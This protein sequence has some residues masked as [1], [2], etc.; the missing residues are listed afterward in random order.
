VRKVRTMARKM[1]S[2]GIVEEIRELRKVMEEMVMVLRKLAREMK[3]REEVGQESAGVEVRTE[4]E[5]VEEESRVE[6]KR[7]EKEERRG[8]KEGRKVEESTTGKWK[9]AEVRKEVRERTVEGR[10]TG[11]GERRGMWSEGEGVKGN[12]R[13]GGSGEEES[14][15]AVFLSNFRLFCS[16][17]R[18]QD[19]E[20][21]GK[22]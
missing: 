13:S 10:R 7:R 5:G 16:Y 15:T 4:R 14:I 9:A 1:E 19:G 17:F 12:G 2:G 22:D 11:D 20:W 8:G 3:R 18:L 21:K 6:G